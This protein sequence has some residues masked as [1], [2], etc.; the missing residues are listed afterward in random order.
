[1]KLTVKE[2]VLF[3][4]LGALMYS[5]KVFMELFPNIHLIGVFVIALTVVY[6]KKA[7]YP[8]YI[9]VFLSGLFSGFSIG[10]IP[11]LYVWTTLW[12]ITMLLPKNM[13]TKIKPIVYMTLCS[14]HGFLFGIII[15]P[16]Q[17]ILFGLDFNGIIAWVIAGL[18]WDIA[19]GI[20]NFFFGILICPIIMTLKQAERYIK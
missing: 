19:H 2:K 4:M 14:L 18:P 16:S 11:Y 13:P 3:G 5:S 6:R 8:I 12:A 10:W 17:G 7:L 9:F 20:G 15:A 1:M